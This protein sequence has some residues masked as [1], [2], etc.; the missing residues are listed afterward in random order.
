MYSKEELR[1]NQGEKEHEPP[2]GEEASVFLS[3]DVRGDK[4]L[5]QRQ[6][7]VEMNTLFVILSTV[8]Q[9]T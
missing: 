1:K 5:T 4:V 3:E 2:A 8:R 7:P 9:P 6:L